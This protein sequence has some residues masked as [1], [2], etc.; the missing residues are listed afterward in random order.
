[1]IRLVKRLRIS[2]LSRNRSGNF[3]AADTLLWGDSDGS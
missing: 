3:S 2:S 1:M